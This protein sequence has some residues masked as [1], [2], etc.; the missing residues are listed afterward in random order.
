MA[1]PSDDVLR[2][3]YADTKTIAVV[4]VSTD[5]SKP[6]N[7]VPRYMQR[8]GFRV[9][10]ITPKGGELLGETA[11]TSLADAGAEVDVVDVFRPAE[12]APGIAE[13]AVKL[14]AKV[15]WLQAGI[16]SDEA[17]K[18]ARDGGL[19]VVQDICIGVTHGRLGLGPG[20]YG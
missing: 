16:F 5:E 4:G 15:L 3:I 18:I 12:E 14:G 9:I 7:I 20:P 17:E 6:S 10:P 8:Q 19:E 1:N 11:Y 13:Q 2:Q